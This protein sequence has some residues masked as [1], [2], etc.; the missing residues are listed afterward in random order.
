MSK[1]TEKLWSWRQKIATLHQEQD[2]GKGSEHPLYPAVVYSCTVQPAAVQLFTLWC[3]VV[4]NV[5][6]DWINCLAYSTVASVAKVGKV[7]ETVE[8][9]G[10]DARSVGLSH[11]LPGDTIVRYR[12]G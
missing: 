10:G 8:P 3:T 1:W 7:W 12:L 6:L 9:S 4:L 2:A 5:V 11:Y